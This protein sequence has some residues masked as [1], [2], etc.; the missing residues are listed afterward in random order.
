MQP[1][2]RPDHK[3]VAAGRDRQVDVDRERAGLDHLELEVQR[4]RGAEYIE[5]RPEVRGRGRHAHH[6][7]ASQAGCHSSTAR[8]I[9]LSSGSQATTEPAWS[10]AVSGSLRPWPVSTHTTRRTPSPAPWTSKPATLA[11][12][13]GS[14]NTPSFAA[15]K[16]YAIRI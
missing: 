5:A 10:S 2:E 14:Q 1:L 8:S 11:A 12:E 15:R 7:P 9:A 3:I 4:E 16:R 13:A 6:A